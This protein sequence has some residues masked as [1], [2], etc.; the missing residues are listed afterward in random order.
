[1]PSERRRGWMR[2][3]RRR[4]ERMGEQEEEEDKDK[5]RRRKRRRRSKTDCEAWLTKRGSLVPSMSAGHTANKASPANLMIS[6]PYKWINPRGERHQQRP[7][8]KGRGEE[9]EVATKTIEASAFSFSLIPPF[10]TP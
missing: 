8:A 9:R 4:S 2:R 6:P 10:T 3:M 5:K 7:R 1:M